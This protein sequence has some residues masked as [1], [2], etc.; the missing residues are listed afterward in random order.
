MSYASPLVLTRSS[1][2]LAVTVCV[3]GFIDLRQSAPLRLLVLDESPLWNFLRVSA[4]A[5]GGYADWARYCCLS[6]HW[7]HDNKLTTCCQKQG[8]KS[9]N[10]NRFR[11]RFVQN[12]DNVNRAPSVI[13][14]PPLF[15]ILHLTCYTLPVLWLML[16]SMGVHSTQR[17]A[18]FILTI[19][20]QVCTIPGPFR[21][22]SLF[23]T[24]SR[25]SYTETRSIRV[26]WSDS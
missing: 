16:L 26:S 25:T 14:V 18:T 19:G 10:W 8:K 12:L 11:L 17:K 9:R 4:A 24:Q 7:I 1:S 15:L 23:M 21:R 22:A 3:R 13:N 2:L 5:V 6:H 20:I